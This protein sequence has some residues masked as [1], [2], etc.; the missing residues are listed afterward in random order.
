M[1]PAVVLDYLCFQ[2]FSGK[3]NKT[4]RCFIFSAHLQKEDGPT[5]ASP[6]TS[7]LF[8]RIVSIPAWTSRGEDR[9]PSGARKS[10]RFTAS[11]HRPYTISCIG[12]FCGG[13]VFFS[14]HHEPAKG[15]KNRYLRHLPC[16]PAA[17]RYCGSVLRTFVPLKSRLVV[18]ARVCVCVFSLNPPSAPFI[19]AKTC[20][21]RIRSGLSSSAELLLSVSLLLKYA[22]NAAHHAH[23]IH[24]QI[25]VQVLRKTAIFPSNRV[26][27]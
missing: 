4:K 23:R 10:S 13:L 25:Q 8:L 20:S 21:C 18:C 1:V 24:T 12:A 17:E 14:E 5:S 3:K 19:C 16:S 2:S 26:M 9:G 7:L 6:A 27:V 11:Y 22:Q 15:Q